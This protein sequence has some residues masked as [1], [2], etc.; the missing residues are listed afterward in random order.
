MNPL[1]MLKDDHRTVEMLFQQFE[2]IAEKKGKGAAKTKKRLVDKIIREL[3][4]HAAIEEQILYP[5]SRALVSEA[6]DKV[7]EALE[8]HH[9]VKWTLSEIAKM[10]P[11]H[12]RFDAK[13]KVLIE[14]VRH[15]VKEEEGDL[16]KKLRQLPKEELERMGDELA[17]AK[18]SAPVRPHPRMPDTPPG[19]LF[20]NVIGRIERARTG[21]KV[22]ARMGRMPAAGAKGAS[23]AKGGAKAGGATR[24]TGARG[25][26][27]AEATEQG[28]ARSAGRRSAP[29]GKAGR[30][31]GRAAS[32]GG[33]SGGAKRGSAR[34]TKSSSRSG[35]RK[36]TGGTRSKST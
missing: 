4:I 19:N 15:H 28:G 18:K 22:A 13:V 35:G 21:D 31:S 23:R 6:E 30:T 9:I 2:A 20:A 26:G 24:S 8:E 14:S 3:S 34:G 17:Q 29:G 11:E 36:S 25:R 5:Q 33:A 12:E 7:L 32:A 27:G 16:F 1:T 10:E